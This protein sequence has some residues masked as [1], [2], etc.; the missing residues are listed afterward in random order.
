MKD[1]Q[2]SDGLN[3]QELL[4]SLKES[5]LLSPQEQERAEAIRPEADG[6]TLARALVDAGFLTAFQMDAVV[7]R[8]HEKLR[9]G[10]YDILDKLGA[11]GMGSVY[12]ARHR[13]MKRIVAL[14]V[15]TRSLGRDK[16]FVQR[17]QREVETLAQLS[18]PNITMA[19]DADEAKAGHYLVMEFVD[20][21]DLA[22][23]V[24]KKGPLSV[25]DAVD[26][27]LQTARGL[28]YVHRLGMIHRDIKPANLLRDANGVVKVTD[29]GLARLSG[30]APAASGLTQAGGMLGT[31]DYMPPEQAV[32][33]SGID[34]RADIY[35]LGATMFFLLTGAP[36]YPGQTMMDTVFK[37]REAPIPSLTAVRPEVPPALDD[38]FRRM[39]AKEPADRFQSMTDVIRAL[40]ALSTGG[41][42]TA[43]PLPGGVKT[44]SAAEGPRGKTMIGNPAVNSQTMTAPPLSTAQGTAFKVLLVEPS[45]TQASIIKK[46]LQSQDIQQV[47]LVATGQEALKAVTSERPTVIISAMHLENNMSGVQ[48]AQQVRAMNLNQPP[49]FVLI[50]SETENAAVGTLSTCGQALVL[51]K[52]FGLKDLI[53]TLNLVSGRS[54]TVKPAPGITGQSLAG[55]ASVATGPV[56]LAGNRRGQMRVLV[57]DDSST[58][59]LHLRK[60]LKELGFEQFV[61]AADGAQAVAATAREKFDLIVTDYNMPFLDGGALVGYLK[62]NPATMSVPILLLTSEAD[63]NKLEALRQLGAAAV[64]DKTFSPEVVRRIVDQL[65]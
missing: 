37:H 32:D 65:F 14:K 48:L 26:C 34:H 23:L 8:R 7:N 61:E 11:G 47:V 62:Q 53:E 30:V 42:D 51:K 45:R 31:V 40:E 10:N 63:P 58:A 20:G 35:S 43:S 50:S 59:R 54:L 2:V 33:P 24:N 5:M 49:G 27:T 1:L 41:R 64:C 9:I 3:R 17:F 38:V 57:V 60:V 4:D 55:T 25:A 56:P 44:A 52:P 36:P 16:T 28:E 12:K 19:Y 22:S 6:A 13:R 29:L 15:L 39:L 46:Y 21:Q 18:H